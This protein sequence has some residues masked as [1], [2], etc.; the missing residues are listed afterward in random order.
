[1][2]TCTKCKKEK[3]ATTEYYHKHTTCKGGLNTV[4]KECFNQRY[5]EQYER[6]EYAKKYK[7]RNPKQT[8]LKPME[9]ALPYT[10]KPKM[11]LDKAEIENLNFKE[12]KTYLVKYKPGGKGNGNIETFKGELIQQTKEF[13]IL[14]NKSGIRESFLKV[15]FMIDTQI[16]EVK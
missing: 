15:D 4:C 14:K 5:R 2:K 16:K 1:M 12:G 3:P 13:I 7:K 6:G 11:A 8:K 9:K 10:Q